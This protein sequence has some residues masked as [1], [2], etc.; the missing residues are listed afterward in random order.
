[1]KMTNVVFGALSVANY[2]YVAATIWAAPSAL[3]KS[4]HLL[5]RIGRATVGGSCGLYMA[6]ALMRRN[7]LFGSGWII[8]WMMLCGAFNFYVGVALPG[9]SCSDI[10]FQASGTMEPGQ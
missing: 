7:E 1:M 3:I 9:P 10:D 6:A 5:E 4:A 2:T 8:F